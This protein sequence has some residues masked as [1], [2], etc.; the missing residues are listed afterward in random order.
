VLLG[1]VS[2]AATG[3]AAHPHA[4]DNLLENSWISGLAVLSVAGLLG[5]RLCLSVDFDLG[6][7]ASASCVIAGLLA[8]AAAGQ[9]PQLLRTSTIYHA[10]AAWWIPA[11]ALAA[12]FNVSM[13]RLFRSHPNGRLIPALLRDRP[14]RS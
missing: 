7:F 1:Y 4:L 3:L 5:A 8:S 11:F 14:V 12:G 10:G 9:F 2:A 6:V 13:H